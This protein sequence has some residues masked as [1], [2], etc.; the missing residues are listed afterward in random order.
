MSRAEYEQAFKEFRNSEQGKA[1][2]ERI[3]LKVYY[4]L[5]GD[6]NVLFHIKAKRLTKIEQD[7]F[8]V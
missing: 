5:Q 8:G 6:S 1:E 4:G 3:F 2:I 7:N